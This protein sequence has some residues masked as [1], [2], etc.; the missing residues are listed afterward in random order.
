MRINLNN[1]HLTGL[2]WVCQ[3][4]T[5]KETEPERTWGTYLTHVGFDNH[6][7]ARAWARELAIRY[8]SVLL[9]LITAEQADGISIDVQPRVYDGH[10]DY[11]PYAIEDS[12]EVMPG[13]PLTCWYHEECHI[14]G[15]GKRPQ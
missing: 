8:E 10:G 15:H 11:E 13:R 14:N 9:R 12:Y 2:V 5:F 1:K 3:T 7:A 6:D 4:T